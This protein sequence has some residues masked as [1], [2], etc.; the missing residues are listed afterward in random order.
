MILPASVE[1]E[2]MMCRS[3]QKQLRHRQFNS[4]KPADRRAALRRVRRVVRQRVGQLIVLECGAYGFHAAGVYDCG[5]H[6]LETDASYCWEDPNWSPS[7]D[8]VLECE[9]P[10]DSPLWW[11]IS[12]LKEY[13]P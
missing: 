3:L 4:Q 13:Q 2:T 12:A 1:R 9:V 8:G 5:R 7:W 11:Q 10:D 6:E